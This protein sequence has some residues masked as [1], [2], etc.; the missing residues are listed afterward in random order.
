MTGTNGKGVI[1][2]LD[3]RPQTAEVQEEVEF[4]WAQVLES[5]AFVGGELVERFESE[6][7]AYCGTSDSIGVGNGTDALQLS[8][9]AL[10]LGPGDEVIVPSNTFVATAEAV[11]MSGAAPRF[12]DVDP[13][14]LLL[15]AQTMKEAMTDRTKAVIAVHLYGQMPDMDELTQA[16]ADLGIDVIEDAAQ[17]HGATWRGR[18]A[19][20]IGRVGCFSF[21]PGKNLGAFGDAGAI[22][23]S[24]GTLAERLRSMRDHGRV[25]GHHYAH[26]SVGTNSRLDALQAVVLTAKLRP[27]DGWNDRRRRVVD[28]YR[29]RLPQSIAVMVSEAVGARSVYHLAVA[30]VSSRDDVRAELLAS[31]IQTGIHYPTP[32][33]VIPAYRRYSDHQLPVVEAAASRI[34]SLP[35]GPHMTDE[36]VDVVCTTLRSIGRRWGLDD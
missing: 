32:C 8:L 14:T 34:L 18:R 5:S 15:T 36:E 13:D 17:A 27:L 9:R 2:F 26:G 19:G 35:L 29:Q 7:A 11:V 6:W 22:V 16:S 12:A 20:S 28:R 10:D 21:Y 3:L 1:R 4:G 25:A 31:G 30:R 33:H 24:D 23:T